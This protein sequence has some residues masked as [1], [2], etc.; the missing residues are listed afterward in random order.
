M[1]FFGICGSLQ[2]P[3]LYLKF[4]LH[5]LSVFRCL[6][7]WKSSMLKDGV[8]AATELSRHAELPPETWNMLTNVYL[9]QI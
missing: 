7:P 3:K 9:G 5:G 6:W 4:Q 2:Q 8:M 1:F